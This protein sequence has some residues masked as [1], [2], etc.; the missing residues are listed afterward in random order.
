MTNTPNKNIDYKPSQIAEAKFIV[1]SNG[2]CDSHYV[3]RLIN[4]GKLKARN[5]ALNSKRPFWLI[6]GSEILRYK[7]S[8]E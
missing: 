2:N 6:S 8:I 5:Y 1:N 4:A 3:I 7:K